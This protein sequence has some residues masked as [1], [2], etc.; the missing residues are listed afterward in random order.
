MLPVYLIGD[1]NW[2]MTQAFYHALPAMHEEGI[3]LCWPH[4]P[5]VS[6]GCHQDWDEFDQ[7]SR[8]PVVRRRVGGTLVY[9]DHH[10][11]FFQV[12]L[13]PQRHPHLNTPDKWY[14]YALTP[15]IDWLKTIGLDARFKAPA[16]ILVGDRKIS[17]NAGGQIED[18]VVI[19]GNILL[20]FSPAMMAQVRAGSP[21]FKQT[22]AEAMSRHLVTLEELSNRSWSASAVMSR[23]ALS[24]E[25]HMAADIQEVPWERWRPLL[26]QVGQSLLQ[27]E[28]LHAAGYRPPYHQVKVRE[29]VYLRQ[30]R[31]PEF[32]DV[33]VEVDTENR[34]LNALWNTPVNLPLPL[35]WEQ[36]C[37][38]VPDHALLNVLYQLLGVPAKDP[39]L[40]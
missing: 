1:V 29:G 15:V 39:L 2:L 17:G 6:L 13:N 40:S 36:V 32:P 37:D 14:R 10:Q 20:D 7:T 18:R 27:P 25:K 28:W 5:Y 38:Y 12:V 11:V 30:T 34:L 3:I 8:V 19:V 23:L 22:F 35:R 24:F 26:D 16:D 21:I 9:L 33:V 31:Q 4:E